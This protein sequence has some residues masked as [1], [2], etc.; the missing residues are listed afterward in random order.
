M[1][2]I[3]LSTGKVAIVDDEDFVYLS[4]HK[5][6]VIGKGYAA[7]KFG[8]GKIRAMHRIILGVTDSNI[9]IDHINGNKLDNRRSNLRIAD[10]RKNHQ[11]QTV[12]SDSR[13]GYKGVSFDKNI[14]GRRPWRA[15]ITT[16]EKRELHLGYFATP[17]EAA[18]AYD[19][20]AIQFFGEFARI[21]GVRK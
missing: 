4:R 15:K 10:N 14:K 19:Q 18:L 20:S 3:V 11:N 21:N 8:T 13:S 17:E 9:H 12:R 6:C 16:K 1:K 5:W 2:S 7:S